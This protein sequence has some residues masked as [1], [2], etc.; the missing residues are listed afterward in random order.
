MGNEITL[1]TIE[2]KAKMK[3]D[4]G[5]KYKILLAFGSY[6]FFTS[7]FFDPPME[8]LKGL[9][10]ILTSPSALITDYFEL[11][12]VGASLANAAIMMFFAILL[13]KISGAKIT[14]IVI[15]SVIMVAAFSLFGKNPY[16]AMSIVFGVFLYSKIVRKPFKDFILVALFGTCLGP[17]V[18]EVSF[19]M[20]F[21]SIQGIV[22]G[23]MLGIFLGILIAYF[24]P[25]CMSLHKGMML[26]NIGFTAGMISTV[27]ITLMR[28]MGLKFFAE[29][30]L[31]TGENARMGIV[32]IILFLGM[33]IYGLKENGWSL[34]GYGRLLS[35]PGKAG[36]DFIETSG[37]GLSLINMAFLG[38]LSMGYIYFIG[39]HLSGPSIG[40][41][42]SVMGFGASGKH[43]KN[44][45]PV[46]L[47]IYIMAILGNFDVTQTTIIFAMTFGTALAPISGIYGP[48]AGFI[49]GALHLNLV[50]HTSN[51]HAGMNLYNNGFS[52]GIIAMVLVPLLEMIRQW[53]AHRMHQNH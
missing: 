20:D 52:A 51:L 24:A 3:R 26:Y 31:P 1:D 49:A 25:K 32:L 41:I 16:N 5:I 30:H 37:I 34:K 42:F 8:I 27:I 14:G 15:A 38:F 39:G 7:F 17:L 43:L 10:I 35:L 48:L 29:P 36:T 9:K 18:S 46:M 2:I 11:A 28:L 44:V 13:V 21:M 45:I 23:K 6:L 12:G 22:L 53:P 19:N 40:G 33:I 4:E 50:V 47:G